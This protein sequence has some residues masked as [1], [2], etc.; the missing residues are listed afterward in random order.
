MIIKKG[1]KILFQG[2]SITDSGRDR[3]N[4]TLGFGYVN[5]ISAFFQSMYPEHGCTFINRGISGNRSSDLCERWTR[6]CIDLRPDVLSIM[7]GINDTWRK[8]DSNDPTTIR[9]F[10][11]ITG[12]SSRVP[13]MNWGIPIIMSSVCAPASGGQA[14]VA[15]GFG[16]ENPKDKTACPGIWSN[17]HTP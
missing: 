13:Q 9:S 16:P 6:D 3:E 5:Y 15:R 14:A 4:D 17:I 12:K 2:D 8:F 7:I 1:S 10:M 11:I